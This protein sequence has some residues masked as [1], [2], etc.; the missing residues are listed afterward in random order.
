MI[1]GRTPAPLGLQVE[2]GTK[3]GR[4]RL[5]INWDP[6]EAQCQSGF[7]GPVTPVDGGGCSSCSSSGGGGT[8]GRSSAPKKE[9]LVG[10]KRE[11]RAGP[12]G[13]APRCRRTG[14]WRGEVLAAWSNPP[15]PRP[16]PL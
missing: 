16:V 11:K 1:G 13:P 5:E 2:S 10:G 9:E 14:W 3:A 15:P 7:S 4:V 12:G 8:W 6:V